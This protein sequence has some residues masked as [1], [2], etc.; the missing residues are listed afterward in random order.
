[1]NPES[2]QEQAPSRRGRPRKFNEEFRRDALEQMK[3]CTNIAELARQLGIRRKWLYHW[4]DQATGRMSKPKQK[5]GSKR[6][7]TAESRDQKRIRELERLVARQALEIDFF[8][9]AL[10]RIE[11]KRRKRE[12]TSGMP[13]TSK[14]DKETGSK[15]N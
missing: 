15:A 9:G 13:S 8:K 1:M 12:Q 10:L 6:A 5:P 2:Q 11:E 3:T 4:R 7:S 14:S